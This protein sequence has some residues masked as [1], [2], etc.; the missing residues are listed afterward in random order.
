MSFADSRADPYGLGEGVEP[1]QGLDL[2][3]SAS[4]SAGAGSSYA[5]TRSHSGPATTKEANGK[6]WMIFQ[7]MLE[8]MNRMETRLKLQTKVFLFMDS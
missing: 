7:R 3:E 8:S 6:R 4:A 1:S 5:L 2:G